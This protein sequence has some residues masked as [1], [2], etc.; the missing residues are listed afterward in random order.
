MKNSL[1]C[2]NIVILRKWLLFSLVP[3]EQ[4]WQEEPWPMGSHIELD[5]SASLVS[6]CMVHVDF[7][8]LI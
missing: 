2:G 7:R 3:F 4:A 1:L 6:S 5:A 8:V